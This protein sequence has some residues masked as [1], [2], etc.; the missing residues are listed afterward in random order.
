[1]NYFSLKYFMNIRWC[2]CLVSV[3]IRTRLRFVGPLTR[4][5]GHSLFGVLYSCRLLTQ[6]PSFLKYLFVSC[7]RQLAGN[8]DNDTNFSR[9][10][11][12]LL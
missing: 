9:D 4:L 5:S 12:D 1:M 10:Q 7:S 2:F 6:L 11:C 8:E 3:K